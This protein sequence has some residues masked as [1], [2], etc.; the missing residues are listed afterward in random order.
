MDE[1]E[2]VEN[3][4]SYNLKELKYKDIASLGQKNQDEYAKKM[5]ILSTNMS[6]EEYNELSMK[7]GLKIQKEINSLNGFDEDFQQPLKE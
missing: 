2:V 6:E 7:E 1:N 3:K 4:K 5:M